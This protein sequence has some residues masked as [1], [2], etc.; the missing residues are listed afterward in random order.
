VKV[1]CCF[2]NILYSDS[3][4]CVCRSFDRMCINSCGEGKRASP[5]R[6]TTHRSFGYLAS[7][8]TITQLMIDREG[9]EPVVCELAEMAEEG[10]IL[11]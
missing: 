3:C 11:L 9:M 2:Q 7:D 6:L 1:I 8:Y 5:V 10:C 4:S